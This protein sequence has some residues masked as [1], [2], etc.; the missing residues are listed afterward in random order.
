MLVLGLNADPC[1][2]AA[3]DGVNSTTSLFFT[4][5]ENATLPFV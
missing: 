5:T 3:G 1:A 2:A 4:P